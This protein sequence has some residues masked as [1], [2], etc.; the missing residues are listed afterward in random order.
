MNVDFE[1]YRIF[2][3]VASN[4][5]ITKAAEEL[6]ISQPAISKSIKNLESQLGG[7][8][9]VRTKRGV[10]LTSEGKEFYKYIS[11]AIEITRNAESRFTELINLETGVIKIGIS[12]TLTKMFLIPYIKKFHDS[13]PNI[14]IKI[15]TS[16]SS[17]LLTKLRN[18]LLDMV[19]I[20][21]D[22]NKSYSD[23]DVIKCINIQDIFISNEDIQDVF[24]LKDLSDKSLVLLPKGSKTRKFLDDFA[25]QHNVV[26][27]PNMELAGYSLVIEFVKIGFGVGCVP[28][29]FVRNELASKELFKVNLNVS[30]PKRF[31]GIVVSKNHL[32]SF[33]TKKFIDIIS[34]L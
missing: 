20:I 15:I 31:I 8:L 13:F 21:S 3:V 25:S 18:G 32:P 1:L 19:I 5:N 17:D 33:S 28:D 23:M 14:D 27:K 10:V 26:L 11:Q 12:T 9:F 22:D 7:Q 34:K 29:Y 16:I 6:N 2:C 24:S 4:G 30:L